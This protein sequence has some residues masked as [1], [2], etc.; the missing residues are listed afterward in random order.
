MQV[1][2]YMPREEILVE[3]DFVNGA[4]NPRLQAL[5]VTWKTF[6]ILADTVHPEL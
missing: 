3:G 1:E 6:L 2:L 5:S 4:T